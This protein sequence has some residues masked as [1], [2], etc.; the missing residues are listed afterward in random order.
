MSNDLSASFPF[1]ESDDGQ[2]VVHLPRK[3]VKVQTREDA[4]AMAALPA[5]RSKIMCECAGQSDVTLARTLVRVYKDYHLTSPAVR[6]VA[7][8]LSRQ[9]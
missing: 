5:L 4:E 3:D 1:E 2:W 9:G 8:W 6:H 7:T